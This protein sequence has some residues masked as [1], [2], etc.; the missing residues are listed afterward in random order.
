MVLY[1]PVATH[2][3]I[4]S[5]YIY[6]C[7]CVFSTQRDPELLRA[8]CTRPRRS[9]APSRGGSTRT[10]RRRRPRSTRARSPPSSRPR[11]R[12]SSTTTTRTC[13]WTRP[14]GQVSQT[15]YSL[16]CSPACRPSSSSVAGRPSSMTGPSSPRTPRCPLPA[17]DT[18][19]RALHPPAALHARYK[20]PFGFLPP[21]D[22]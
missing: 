7:V 11:P 14:S 3:H 9:A 15:T 20:L 10:Q 4:T 6:I 19:H 16:R 2:E 17:V 13:R 21:W 1:V 22:L 18:L 5:I 12:S 8:L